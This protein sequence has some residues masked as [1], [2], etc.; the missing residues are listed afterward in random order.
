[1]LAERVPAAALRAEPVLREAVQARGPG[2]ARGRT[3]NLV[4]LSST[5]FQSGQDVEEGVALGREALNGVSTLNSPRSRARLRTL[6]ATTDSYRSIPDVADFRGQPCR[7][8]A[9]VR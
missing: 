6:L 8:V 3:L 7:V 2:Y 4:A 9:D 1:V 5:Y